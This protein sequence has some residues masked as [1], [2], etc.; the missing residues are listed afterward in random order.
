MRSENLFWEL[1]RELTISTDR[2]PVE[3]VPM[4]NGDFVG[5]VDVPRMREGKLGGI[6]MSVW[7]PCEENVEFLN[8]DTVCPAFRIY[9]TSE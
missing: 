7:I 8:P 1:E 3:T 9:N 4:V 6:F 2:R 5:H